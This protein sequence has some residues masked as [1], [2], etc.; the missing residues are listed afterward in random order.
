MIAAA[1]DELGAPDTYWTDQLNNAR[2]HR[3]LPFAGRGD[4]GADGRASRRLRAV[5]GT[6]ASLRGVA[7]RCA[8][9]SPESGSS[10][11][12]R[13]NRRCCPAANPAPHKIEGIGIGYTPPLWD[14]A[15]VDEIIPVPTADA[16]A[17]ARRL[18]RR[19]RVVRGNV[20]RRQRLAAIRVG[21]RL[22]P[23]DAS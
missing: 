12:S 20:V 9:T 4:L 5:V 7:T 14:P 10:R 2:Q 17:M 1:A 19:G 13:A 22:G 21:E 16:E 23:G 3:R 11:S 18:A 8:V 6:A 15:L